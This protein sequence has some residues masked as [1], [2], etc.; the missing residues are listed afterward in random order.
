MAKE[1]FAKAKNN[2]N[3]II[4]FDQDGEFFYKKA[5]KFE[6]NN[7][8]IEALSYYRKAVEKDPENIDYM[9]DLAETFTEMSCFEESNKI[10][11]SMLH[12]NK[13]I[14]DC[15]FGLGCNFLG[16]Q[17]FN[18]AEECFDKYLQVASDGI[19]SNDAR[20]LLD[21]LQNEDFFFSFLADF[22]IEDEQLYDMANKGKYF[23][24][25]GEYKNAIKQLQKVVKRNPQLVFARNN[26]A[27]AYFCNG[28]IDNAVEATED[29]LYDFPLNVHAICNMAI[30]LT[31]RGEKDRAEEYIKSLDNISCTN[32]EDVQKVAVTFCELKRHKEAYK[33]LKLL[34]QYKPYDIRIL[35][36]VAVAAFNIKRYNEALS[37]WG[38]IEKI[39][40]NNTISSYYRRHTIQVLNNKREFKELYYTYEVSYDEILNRVKRINQYMNMSSAEQIRRWREDDTLYNLFNWGVG[41]KDTEIKKAILTTVASFADEKAERFLRN[42]ILKRDEEEEFKKEALA[43]LKKINAKEPYIAYID[44]NIV[45]VRVSLIDLGDENVPEQYKEVSKFTIEN[46]ADRYEEGYE[47]Y[48]QTLW[49]RFIRALYPNNLPR[50]KKIETWAATLEYYYCVVHDIDIRKK[51]LAEHYNV[52]TSSINYNLKKLR[53]IIYA[54]SDIK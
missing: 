30:F 23:I 28:E 15:Y 42:F 16:L 25:N 24:D 49:Y 47:N 19:Y 33:Y 50:I 21:I 10:L 12:D 37:Y 39:S 31:R 51:D 41:F 32:G 29:I 3:K 8:Y 6:E 27:L 36:Y 48:I 35:H 43:L 53:N 40:P 26:L 4:A 38:K 11:F 45:E 1:L 54:K 46:M 9:L 34:L 2:K 52:S 5:K 44:D 7:E 20:D 14:P 18:K 22:D 17:D 13:V